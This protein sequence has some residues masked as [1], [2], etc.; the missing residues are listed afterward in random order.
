MARA[1]LLIYF[2][3]QGSFFGIEFSFGVASQ[4]KITAMS[5]AFELSVLTGWKERERVFDVCGAARVVAQFVL[6][7]LTKS[8]S[9]RIESEVF[10]PLETAVS[11]VLVPVG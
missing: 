10:V 6:F 4:V 11:P 1:T 9:L 7:V 5:D 8:Q 3:F 2:D